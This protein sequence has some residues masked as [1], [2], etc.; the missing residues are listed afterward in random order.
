[1]IRKHSEIFFT[2]NRNIETMSIT[3][4][5]SEQFIDEYINSIYDE[6]S[7]T[8][9]YPSLAILEGKKVYLLEKITN[10]VYKVAVFNSKRTHTTPEY[11]ECYI[12]KGFLSDPNDSSPK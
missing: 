1:M 5:K 4:I 12:W 2:T 9:N 6:S 8:I 11:Y 7:T 10:K 3:A